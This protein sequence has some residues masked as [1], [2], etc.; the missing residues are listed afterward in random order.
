[1]KSIMS[2][3]A[4]GFVL[5]VSLILFFSGC[6]IS[7]NELSF[8]TKNGDVITLDYFDVAEEADGKTCICKAIH[9][10][11][12]QLAASMWKNDNIRVNTLKMAS[13]VNTDGPGEF[14][15][16]LLELDVK[17]API[18]VDTSTNGAYLGLNSYSVLVT[19]KTTRKQCRISARAALFSADTFTHIDFFGL[20]TK[21]KT[22]DTS[23]VEDF[24]AVRSG[25]VT[26]LGRLPI[27]NMFEVAMVYNPQ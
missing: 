8:K 4:A 20:R 18:D 10:R 22:G 5:M 14:V 11:A 9:F 26:N 24:K 13:G 25:V 6:V 3:K 1:M 21:V 2:R 16:R 19:N 12:L 23:A 27:E 7:D 17:I 15:E